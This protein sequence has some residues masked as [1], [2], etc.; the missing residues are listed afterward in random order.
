[1]ALSEADPSGFEHMLTAF[2]ATENPQL[3][4]QC[5]RLLA[6]AEKS[7]VIAV[8]NWEKHQLVAPANTQDL[9]SQLPEH[10]E[11]VETLS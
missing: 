9:M 2:R 5:R 6:E 10:T 3:I 1:M 11:F 8:P 7:G 4:Q